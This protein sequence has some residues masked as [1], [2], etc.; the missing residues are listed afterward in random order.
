MTSP[1]S[2]RA[3]R[4]GSAST[5]APAEVARPYRMTKGLLLWLVF[6]AASLVLFAMGQ[7]A[8]AV[9]VYLVLDPWFLWQVLVARSRGF[10]PVASRFDTAERTVWLTIDDGPDP[11]STPAVLDL[12]D[13]YGARGTFFLIGERAARHPELV[14]EIHRRGHGIGNH[15][16][17]HPCWSFW[18]AGPARVGREIE[19]CNAA[20]ARAGVPVPRYFRMPVGMKTPFFEV[21]LA[22]RGLWLVAWSARGFDRTANPET[23]MRRIMRSVRP[24]AILLLHE[25][26]TAG[27]GVRLIEGV[28]QRLATEGY[29]AVLP[30]HGALN[31]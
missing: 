5:P 19:A 13:Q 25:G 30:D 22:R 3:G 27:A 15:T 1:A 12:L 8:A 7:T 11:R 28:L 26:D 24:G 20:V 10:G 9:A 4:P 23:A 2:P 18:A 31:L 16:Q 6:K 17:T 14:A 21:A 29:R